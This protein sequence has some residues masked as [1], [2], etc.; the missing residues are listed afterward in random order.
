MASNVS[1]SFNES[2]VSFPI[3]STIGSMFSYTDNVSYICFGSLIILLNILV[4]AV[5]ISDK[6]LLRK[7]ALVAGIAAGNFLLGFHMLSF[8]T[9][10]FINCARPSTIASFGSCA[11]MVFPLVY[12][13]AFNTEAIFMFL[14]GLERL[15]AIVTPN[16][17][18]LK[19]T[20]RN[21]W[22]CSLLLYGLSV[23][24]MIG[25]I[26][27]STSARMLV[28]WDCSLV[29]MFGSVYVLF[30]SGFSASAS[31]AGAAFT[32]TAFG[33]G[34]WRIRKL[35]L[36][37]GDFGRMRKQLQLTKSMA[38]ISCCEVAFMALP[39]IFS[40]LTNTGVRLPSFIRASNSTYTNAV[41]SVVMVVAFMAFHT[42]FRRAAINLVRAQKLV[43]FFVNSSKVG[44]K[45]MPAKQPVN[46]TVRSAQKTSR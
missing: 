43:A 44:N 2:N 3:V 19:W 32:L 17:F 11:A 22:I 8:G 33:F 42:R 13:M 29:S 1:R 28:S 27:E 12:P 41:N 23:I 30:L 35:P 4:M 7:S 15:L 5:L 34:I 37:S 20:A 40:L 25:G 9:Y 14:A 18:R 10:R 16:W 6:I 39:N 46:I 24:M 31:V 36:A 26:A 21:A 38:S 45:V